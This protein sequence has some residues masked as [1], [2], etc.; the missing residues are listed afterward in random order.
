VNN[1]KEERLFFFFA[2][3][4]SSFPF[5]FLTQQIRR[6]QGKERRLKKNKNKKYFSLP[7]FRDCGYYISLSLVKRSDG[8][9]F[10][11]LPSFSRFH[12][13]RLELCRRILFFLE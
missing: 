3:C 11:F 13:H 9:S 1:K 2:C 5:F 6:K 7:F 8:R 12:G 10:F 4:V